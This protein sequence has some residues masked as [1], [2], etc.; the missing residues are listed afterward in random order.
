MLNPAAK[1]LPALGWADNS[2]SK[3]LRASC[4]SCGGSPFSGTGKSRSRMSTTHSCHATYAGTN[5]RALS[6]VK[7]PPY[8]RMRSTGKS[9]AD[10]P[11]AINALR[12]APAVNTA[13]EITTAKLTR[14]RCI[15]TLIHNNSRT[16][17]P[18]LSSVTSLNVTCFS[19]DSLACASRSPRKEGLTNIPA[20]IVNNVTRS[21]SSHRRNSLPLINARGPN[22]TSNPAASQAT[23][24]RQ[25]ARRPVARARIRKAGHVVIPAAAAAATSAARAQVHT[26]NSGRF[27]KRWLAS[28][29]PVPRR[30]S[31]TL[32]LAAASAA[33]R[34]AL[35]EPE[36]GTLEGAV[37][38]VRTR[39]S[40]SR[41]RCAVRDNPLTARRRL[42][43]RTR[44][45]V[46]KTVADAPWCRVVDRSVPNPCAQVSHRR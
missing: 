5:V 24:A 28:V 31:S 40:V 1:M 19:A 33:S 12:K 36:G 34:I 23:T 13:P 2:A 29:C 3:S 35:P 21:K 11:S 45:P 4:Q 8:V 38:S 6:T 41:L 16:T 25:T 17:R 15:A 27:A 14:N 9:P 37:S 43:D 10:A 39:H 26:S 46:P 7:N 18:A 44:A 20:T 30:N 42:R 22:I 32:P